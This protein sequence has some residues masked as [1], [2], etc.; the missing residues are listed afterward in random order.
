[1]NAA[2]MSLRRRVVPAAT[3]ALVVAA[4]AGGAWYAFEAIST[5][6]IERVTFAGDL[7][8][9]APAD[10]EA[11]AV[12]IRGVSADSAALAAVREAARRIPWVRDATV[13][14][15]FPDAVE[16][17]LETHEPLARWNE[18]SLVSTRGEV[19]AAEYDGPLPRFHGRDNVAA[20]MAGEYPAI[21]RVVA[22]L[23]ATVTDLTLSARGAWQV[24]LDSGLVL[25][26]GRDDIES[27]LT[28][29]AQA[30]PQ[31]AARGVASKHADL[32]Y[33]NGFALAVDAKLQPQ[34]A[35]KAAK[36][37]KTQR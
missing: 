27:R 35:A 26:L 7:H 18:S 24:A 16:V 1:M 15:H 20:R 28:R 32:R 23:G 10:L 17:T 21:V 12:S 25:E 29:F 2:P 4:L 11:F 30:W 5:Q 33:S 8:R 34:P 19:F 22:P 13:R 14:R 3:A 31:L 9:I 37:N 36:K 6:P